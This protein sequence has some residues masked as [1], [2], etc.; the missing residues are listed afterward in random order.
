MTRDVHLSNGETK[1]ACWLV[2]RNVTGLAE[3]RGFRLY[4]TNDGRYLTPALGLATSNP[5]RRMAEAVAY[6]ERQGWGRARYIRD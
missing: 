1:A 6:G 2:V 3:E 4:W 5:F